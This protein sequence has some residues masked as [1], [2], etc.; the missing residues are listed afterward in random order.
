M[1]SKEIKVKIAK[2][3]TAGVYMKAS[4]PVCKAHHYTAQLHNMISVFV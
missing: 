3:Y 4:P 2:N 1:S